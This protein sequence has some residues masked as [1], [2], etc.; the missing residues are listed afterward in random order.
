MTSTIY[1]F[2]GGQMVT[3]MVKA[4]LGQQIFAPEAVFV[5]DI[6]DKRVLALRNELGICAET[7]VQRAALRDADI[8]VLGVRPQDDW[9]GV[10]QT[11][12]AENETAQFISI[13]AGVTITQI[14]QAAGKTLPLTRIIPNTL[15]ETGY[16]ITGAT[17]TASAKKAL[18]EPFLQSF[19]KVHYI[20]E[21]Q[22]DIYTG[23]GS[24]GANF[25][26]NFYLALTNAGVLGGL[27]RAQ[28][29]EVALENLI[30]AAKM[31]QM[32]GKHPYQLLD[33][34]NSAG[35]VGIT[36][37]HELDQSDFAAG[38]ENAVLAAIARSK[39]LGKE[40]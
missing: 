24:A 11:I 10:V 36:A 40:E 4:A 9:A 14:Q 18:I 30:G 39:A 15:T 31:L 1:A 32:T 22:I 8:I 29:N 38:I 28:A 12:A 27:P 23:Y 20:P 2:G 21:A 3:A 26:Y 6:S 17:L 5:T 13:I 19:G 16:G 25:V 37:Q 35:G 33:I 34:N 7:T